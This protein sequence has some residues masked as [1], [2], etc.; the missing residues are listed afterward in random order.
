[1]PRSLSTLLVCLLITLYATG[2]LAEDAVS[3]MGQVPTPEQLVNALALPEGSGV[4]TRGIRLNM[5][6]AHYPNG[7]NTRLKQPRVV[8]DIKFEYD[9]AQ[10]TDRAKQTLLALGKALNSSKLQGNLFVLEGHT[11]S[12]GTPEYNMDLSKRR[13]KAAEHYLKTVCKVSSEQLI[14]KGFGETRPLIKEDPEARDNRRV[15]VINVD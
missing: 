4:R 11:D 13:A 6:Q 5:S 10:L 12:T 2:V 3:F 15:E 9:T 14:V 1:M 8:L 7:S